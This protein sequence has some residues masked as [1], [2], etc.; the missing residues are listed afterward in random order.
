[1]AD[2]FWEIIAAQIAE[3]KSAKT[4]DDVVRILSDERNL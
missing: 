3:L 2:K 1:M 4:A